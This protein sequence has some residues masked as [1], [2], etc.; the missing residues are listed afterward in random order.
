MSER[1][2]T[3]RAAGDRRKGKTDWKRLDTLSEEE[4]VAA[5]EADPDSPLWTEEELQSAELVMPT[6]AP[7]IPVS[8][9]LD[10]E[11]LDYFKAAGPGYQSRISAVLR[12]YVRARRKV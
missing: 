8:I 5:A 7:K 1:R 3:R 11:V 6:G 2:I 12:S 9:R 10:P 4:I